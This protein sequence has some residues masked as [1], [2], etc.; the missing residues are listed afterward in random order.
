MET[1]AASG[2]VWF[3][4]GFLSVGSRLRTRGHDPSRDGSVRVTIRVLLISL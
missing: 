3:A 1:V 2:P 4:N